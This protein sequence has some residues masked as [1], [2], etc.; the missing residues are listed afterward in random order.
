MRNILFFCCFLLL[1]L[2]INPFNSFAQVPDLA[3]K[4]T[5]TTAEDTTRLVEILPGVRKLEFRKIDDSTQLQILAGNVKL[6]QGKSLFYCDSC[7]INNRAGIFEAFGNVHINDADTADAYSNYLRYLID[8]KIAYLSGNVKLTD[9]KGTLTTSS[10]EY[11]INTKIGIYTT[12]GRVINKNTNLTSGE[13]YYYTDLKDVYFKNNVELKD[14][15]YYLKTD[16]LLYNTETETAR[17]IAYTFIRDSSGREIETTEGFYNLR[18]GKAE[19]GKRPFIKDGRRTIRADKVALDDSTGISQA[20]GNVVIVD[21]AQNT[22]VIAGQ[23]F[24][25]NKKETM[26]ATRKPLMIIKQD[27]D[28]IYITADTLFSARLTD[29]YNSKDSILKDTL[30]GV[31]VISTNEDSIHTDKKSD[32]TNRYFEAFRN[33][34]IFSDS[35]QAICDSMFYSFRDSVFRLYDEPVVWSNEN[36]IT[37]DTILL[38]TKNK[39]ADHLT[40]WENSFMVSKLDPEIFNQVK[41]THME[42][43]FTEGA[44]DSV[45]AKGLAQTIYYLQDEDSSYSGINESSSDI[46]DLYFEKRELHKVV[47]RSAVSG[48]IWPIKQKDP[49]EMRLPD[50]NWHE[51]KRPK[52]KEEMFE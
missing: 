51:T 28:S 9:G 41:A 45:R 27:N 26:L 29:L 44:I 17:F 39:K 47:F 38:F 13:G 37:G 12:G 43:Y 11:D 14:P 19:F 42:G 35:L 30:K 15:A 7:V 22:I 40:V 48:T 24:S 46:L 16:S 52:S 25:N 10:L 33:V 36:Q 50:F 20:E 8:K 21:S 4:T 3:P 18:T 34:R 2:F 5:T 49:R 6:R 31:N 1:W 32:S 23:V